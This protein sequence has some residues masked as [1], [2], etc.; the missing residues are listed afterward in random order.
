MNAETGFRGA[1]RVGYLADLDGIES[2]AVRC[3]RQWSGGNDARAQIARQMIQSLGHEQ[4]DTAYRAL[5]QMFRMF[6][7]YKRRRL[8]CHDCNCG[9]LGADEACFANF[10]AAASEGSREDAM[11]IATLLVRADI[12]PCLLGLAET[13][14]LALRRMSVTGSGHARPSVT[15]H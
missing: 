1:A 10:I 11:M 15:V 6:S 8:I 12:V 2:G 13:V 14:G 7:R 3:L 4:G 5:D 9:C